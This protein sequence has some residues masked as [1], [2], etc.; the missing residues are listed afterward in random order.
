MVENGKLI[1]L[2][3]ADDAALARFSEEIGRWLRKGGLSVEETREPTYGPAGTQ[4]LLAR[5]GR[6]RFDA[7]SL[8]LL[9]LAD[10]LDHVQ[11]ADGIESSLAAGRHVICTHYGLAAVSRLWGQVDPDWLCRI[12]AL[13]PVPD[14]TLF[15]DLPTDGLPQRQL[16][17]SYL[18]AIQCLKR[19]GQEICIVD[20][21]DA[22]AQMLSACKR[23]IA[24]LL[25]LGPPVCDRGAY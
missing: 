7:T 16:R 18:A 22:P 19:N 8:A 11:R 10:R 17:E 23:R 24:H 2:E 14:L 20:E 5:Q 13:C 12:D 9:Y 6:L 25:E 4:I 3:A 15:V 21:G 1:V